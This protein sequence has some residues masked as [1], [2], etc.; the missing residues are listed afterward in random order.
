MKT[1]K[2][3]FQKILNVLGFFASHWIIICALTLGLISFCSNVHQRNSIEKQIES[4]R[5]Y[6]AIQKSKIV[7]QQK[8]ELNLN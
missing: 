3:F 6:H 2:P 7:E 8:K 5:E 1:P 4:N